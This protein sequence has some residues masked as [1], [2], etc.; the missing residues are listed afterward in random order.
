M[1]RTIAE[2]IHSHAKPL[3][4]ENRPSIFA[5]DRPLAPV[6]PLGP[7]PP[8]IAAETVTSAGGLSARLVLTPLGLGLGLSDDN[9]VTA[10]SSDSP[11]RHCDTSRTRC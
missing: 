9:L 1:L 2:V 11:V 6:A 4:K 8:V 5:R 7:A 10:V 3:E